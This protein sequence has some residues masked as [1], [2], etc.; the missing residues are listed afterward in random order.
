MFD[1]S[2]DYIV[3]GLVNALYRFE[4][5]LGSAFGTEVPNN[6]NNPTNSRPTNSR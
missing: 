5:S 2:T 1:Q 3:I 6:A 4:D